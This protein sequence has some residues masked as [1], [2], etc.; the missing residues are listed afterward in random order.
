[1]ATTNTVQKHIAESHTE[2]HTEAGFAALTKI[3]PDLVQKPKRKGRFLHCSRTVN[4]IATNYEISYSCRCCPDPA[5]YVRVFVTTPHGRVYGF[6]HQIEI[7]ERDGIDYPLDEW[8]DAL[9]HQGIQSW[10]IERLQAHFEQQSQDM[11]GEDEVVRC[12]AG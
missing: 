9:R 11:E 5:I 3:Y 7:G 1:M 12:R 4:A 2:S 8:D 10:V 6:P